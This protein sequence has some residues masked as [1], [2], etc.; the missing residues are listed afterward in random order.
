MTVNEA[1][2]AEQFK[3]MQGVLMTVKTLRLLEIT[4]KLFVN[5]I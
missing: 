3:E 1:L 2:Y 4:F 5:A